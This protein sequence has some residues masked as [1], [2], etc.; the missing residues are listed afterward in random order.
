MVVK[1]DNPAADAQAIEAGKEIMKK[2]RVGANV[3]VY[4]AGYAGPATGAVVA[5]I[6]CPSMTALA[7]AETK[8]RADNEYLAW[9][10]GLDKIGT[11]ISDSVYR[12]L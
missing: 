7:E 2:A 11:I 8:L 9:I 4:Q 10:R 5:T 6:E 3:R 1:T 12:E